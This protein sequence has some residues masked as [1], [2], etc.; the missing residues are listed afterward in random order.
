MS[1]GEIQKLRIAVEGFAE[2][3]DIQMKQFIAD[4]NFNQFLEKIEAYGITS[5]RDLVDPNILSNEDL[6][7]EIGMQP[8]QVSAFRTAANK[9]VAENGPMLAASAAGGGQS[10]HGG[11][12]EDEENEERM[13]MD[14]FFML[15][16]DVINS[17]YVSS[18]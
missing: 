11:E 15:R 12:D 7:A 3:S 4:N 8:M 14:E 16:N 10:N 13:T 2:S 17:G 5:M 9:F 1:M 18:S 6:S